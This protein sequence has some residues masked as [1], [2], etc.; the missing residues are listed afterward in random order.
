MK[1]YVVG[2]DIGSSK[3]CAIAGK[4]DKYGKMQVMGV[5]STKCSGIKRG[6][7]VDI[8]STAECIKDCI[9]QMERMIDFDISDIFISIPGEICE[10]IVNRGVV[11]VSSEDREIKKN[12]VD[13]VLK[14]AKII[15]ISS[16]K[17]IIGVI[18][19]QFM[20]DGYDN[21]T[22]PIGMSGLRLEVDA[23]LILSQ[24]TVINNLFKSIKKAGLNLSGMVFQPLGTA[25][26]VLK[27][28]EM[29]IGT[30]LLD[31]GAENTNISVFKNGKLCY[32]DNLALGGNII[33]NDI[34]LCLRIPFSEAEK[35][36]VNYGSGKSNFIDE[37]FKIKINTNYDNI[38][39]ID[40][41]VLTEI[42]TARV[43]EILLLIKKKLMISEE[44]DNVSGVVVV[45]G[46][47]A[48]LKGCS[49]LCKEILD[50]PVRIGIPDYT[51]VG[52]PICAAAVG[53]VK[54]VVDSGKVNLCKEEALDE[55][56][57]HKSKKY[58]K[59][60]IVWDDEK[61]EE[62]TEES[63]NGVF[64]KIRNFFADFF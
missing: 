55:M 23:Q 41:N 64:S 17:E 44:M 39:E 2:V 61:D 27:D 3:V 22:D 38:V 63:S 35:L 7:V 10:L 53:V 62:D 51:G 5:T 52:S 40:Y 20:V 56:R 60:S 33:T 8:D 15:T 57:N 34:S 21:I 14:A 24:S 48:L 13:R 50:K 37:D 31:I 4:L 43:E 46:G 26:V 42:I 58:E 59:K 9:E 49:D 16:D 25:N 19:Q 45:G 32:S 6:I 18:P 11:A 47:I 12:D 54:D 36:K 28:E 29:K 1:E 30:L